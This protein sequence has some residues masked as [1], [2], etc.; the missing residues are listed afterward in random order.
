MW[1]HIHITSLDCR[2]IYVVLFLYLRGQ[3]NFEYINKSKKVAIQVK[4]KSF[5]VACT[6]MNL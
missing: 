6:P 5:E 4:N 2:A 3:F 1:G